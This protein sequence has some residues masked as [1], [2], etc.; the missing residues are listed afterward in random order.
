MPE[1]M[2][3]SIDKVIQDNEQFKTDTGQDAINKKEIW[4]SAVEILLSKLISDSI[5]KQDLNEDKIEII[6]S[7]LKR[8]KYKAIPSLH[9]L[10][11]VFM[12]Y[13]KS[14]TGPTPRNSGVSD[15]MDLR[16]CSYIPYVDYFLTENNMA[17]MMKNI[18]K[19][20]DTVLIAKPTQLFDHLDDN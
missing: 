3:I 1:Q 9:C 8:M 4:E 17:A 2:F 15:A 10:L 5:K 7:G 6:I 12:S 13:F 11:S 19:E 18:G 14:H 20:W 16:H